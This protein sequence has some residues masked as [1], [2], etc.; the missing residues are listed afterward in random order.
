MRAE[1]TE[2]AICVTVANRSRMVS[3]ASL[4]DAAQH[5]EVTLIFHQEIRD[6]VFTLAQLTIL[7]SLL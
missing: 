2:D 1:I 7:R 3:I 6:S 5:Q 4:A